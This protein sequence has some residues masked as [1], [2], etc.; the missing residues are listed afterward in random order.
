MAKKNVGANKVEPIRDIEK[1]ERMKEYLHSQSLRNQFLFS[2]GINSGLKI[3]DILPLTVKEVK[4]ASHLTIQEKTGNIRRIKMT[5]SLKS[6]IEEYTNGKRD[7][8]YLF[9]SREGNK[10]ISRV[11]A[12]NILKQAAREVGIK[13]AIGTATLRKTFGYHYYLKTNDLGLLQQIFG[14][15]SIAI[16][17]KFIG[18]MGDISEQ[19]LVDLSF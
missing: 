16:T 18:V 15:S 6:E 9:P 12:W 11:T 14:H 8:E 13:E 3:T 5:S 10:P 1:I 4:Y 2:F 7:E 17:K 19:T